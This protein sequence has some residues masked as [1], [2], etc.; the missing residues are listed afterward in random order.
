MGVV[1]R[2][3]LMVASISREETMK[4]AFIQLQAA[5][6]KIGKDQTAR[7]KTKTGADFSYTYASL[8]TILAAILPVLHKHGFALAQR[9]EKE[10]GETVLVTELIHEN[11]VMHGGKYPLTDTGDI[12]DLGSA[13][14]YAR[15]YALTALLGLAPDD[16]DDGAAAKKAPRAQANAGP[17]GP[18]RAVK[19]HAIL[20]TE[21]GIK[22]PTKYAAE[23]LD[24]H[25]GTLAELSEKDAAKVH[26]AAVAMGETN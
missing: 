24:R 26:K 18:E 9:I 10:H 13:I 19:L 14:T 2:G 1:K 20:E 3:L 11:G 16:D 15:R 21:L 6:P 23:V 12:Q 22:T 4:A 8:P 7:V 25:V 17:I 5:L